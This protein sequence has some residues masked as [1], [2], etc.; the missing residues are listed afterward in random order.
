MQLFIKL[1]RMANHKTIL[2]TGATGFLGSELLKRFILLNYDINLLVRTNNYTDLEERKIQI[3]RQIGLDAN[4]DSLLSKK[5][6]LFEGDI[7]SNNPGL[8]NYD[9]KQ[10]IENVD[11][12]F[13]CAAATKFSGLSR[14]YLLNTNY[15]GTKN[16]LEFCVSGYK[17][18]LHYISTAYVAGEK[19]GIVYEN[20]LDKSSG[21][22]NYYEESKYLA[23]KAVHKCAATHNLPFTIYRPS[24]IIGDSQTFFTVNFD[25]IYI[26]SRI[27]FFLKRKYELMS[28]RNG[29]SAN[30]Q[31]K[32]FG[33]D[34]VDGIYNIPIRIPANPKATLNLVPVDFVINTII[35]IFLDKNRKKQNF[36]YRKPISS[37]FR[38][39]FRSN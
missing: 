25:S 6:I 21:F 14:E 4:N 19:K 17:K 32:T 1:Q 36:S 37:K 20:E 38:V 16:I 3:L 5:I 31:L 18:H 26:F 10:L 8:N 7:T 30:N 29:Y 12:V 33:I 35:S 22:R 39:Y 2:L 15:K 28:K 13:H 23:E 11:E 24:V 9:L 27:L 34:K